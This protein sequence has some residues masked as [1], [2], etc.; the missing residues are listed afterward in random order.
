[1]TLELGEHLLLVHGRPLL[2]ASVARRDHEESDA[3][4]TRCRER[5]FSDGVLSQYDVD[6]TEHPALA[7]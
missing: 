7:I 1:M 3:V 4:A 2:V 6:R 5:S